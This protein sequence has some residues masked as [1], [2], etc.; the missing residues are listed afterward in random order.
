MFRDVV[1]LNLKLKPNS[2]VGVAWG[3]PPPPP[4]QFQ[5]ALD[6]HNLALL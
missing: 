4:R 6:Q 5:K 3:P 2:G 1:S